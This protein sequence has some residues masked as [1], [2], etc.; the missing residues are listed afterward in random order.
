MRAIQPQGARGSLKWIQ[1]L[2]N[3]HADLLNRLVRESC[4]L[5]SDEAI[6]WVSPLVDDQYAEYRDAAFLRRLGVE[7][8]TLAAPRVLAPVRTSMGRL[9]PNRPGRRVSGRSQGEHP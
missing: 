1:V 8:G 2:V 9:G 5:E 7:L 3:Q 4:R 6:E